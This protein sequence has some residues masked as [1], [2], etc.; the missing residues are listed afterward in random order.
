[1]RKIISNHVA[2]ALPLVVFCLVIFAAGALY[3]FLILEFGQPTFDQYIPAGDVK[4]FVMMV[5]YG[6]PVFILIVGV[7]WLVRSGLK[8]E[9]YP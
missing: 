2:S 1:M 7:I 8:Q 5:I 6:I 4:T 9:V 3:T